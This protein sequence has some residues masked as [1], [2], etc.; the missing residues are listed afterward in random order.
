[1]GTL[2]CPKDLAFMEGINKEIPQLAGIP[3]EFYE[4]QVI[5]SRIDPLYQSATSDG[6]WVVIGPYQIEAIVEKPLSAFLANSEGVT[7]AHKTRVTFSRA[8]MREKAMPYPKQGDLVRFWDSM[9]DVIQVEDVSP[10]WQTGKMLNVVVDL[11]RHSES[12]PERKIL[13]LLSHR[14]NLTQQYLILNQV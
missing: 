13:P 11:V 9:F 2:I 5:S 10:F 14:A 6:D 4:L 1:M 12:V 7:I 3:V 8:L